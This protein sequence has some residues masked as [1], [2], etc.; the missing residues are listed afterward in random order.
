[1]ANKSRIIT[2]D[3][4]LNN[5]INP[6]EFDF[7]F[8]A[9]VQNVHHV[10]LLHAHIPQSGYVFQTTRNCTIQFIE[11]AAPAVTL[12]ATITA[13][14]YNATDLATHLT[15]I[16]TA[17]SAATGLGYVYTVQ[18]SDDVAGV[19]ESL[20]KFRFSNPTGPFQLLAAQPN[21][22]NIE[23]GFQ[24][25][26][27]TS[28]VLGLENLIFSPGQFNLLPPQYLYV[29]VDELCDQIVTGNNS[30][31]GHFCIPLIGESYQVSA[32]GVNSFFS[33]FLQ[34]KS[35]YQI[36]NKF[37]IRVSNHK[38]ESPNLNLHWLMMLELCVD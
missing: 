16:M 17:S 33:Y 7:N 30:G 15:A 14:N 22:P 4:Q 31:S 2:I 35:P 26:T 5:N 36:L 27:V 18:V 13:G 25:A 38:G 24:Y 6:N 12:I 9:S 28:Y 19:L 34:T 20:H 3:S 23:L 32:F 8:N 11:T 29:T 21:F 10:R 37:H 1:M